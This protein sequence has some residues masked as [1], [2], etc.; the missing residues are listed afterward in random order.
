M[1]IP[2]TRLLAL[3]VCLLH[4]AALAQPNDTPAEPAAELK[5]LTEEYQTTE[6]LFFNSLSQLKSDAEREEA[7]KNKHPA[8]E[9][10]PRFQALEKRARGTEPGA[11]ALVWILEK[12]G[13]VDDRAAV[14]GAL[15]ALSTTY[16]QSPVIE[17]AL[18]RLRHSSIDVKERESALRAIAKQSPHPKV[19]A[20]ANF[21]LATILLDSPAGATAAR[22]EARRL[23]ET[24]RKEYTGTPYAGQAAGFLFE[25][26]NLQIGMRAPD[27][28][29]TDQD[30][31]K[32]KL[33]DYQGK[34][35]VLDFWGFW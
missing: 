20:A 19:K 21:A 29:A 25:L 13:M 31:K 16:V 33:S 23:F 22:S 10:I 9:F 27:F 7:W 5:A 2:S 18:P 17:Q 11:H 24:V 32:F 8:R 1:K 28:E 12:G 3:L 34:V 15:Q 26:D 4:A 30:G 6:R 14:E 35:V